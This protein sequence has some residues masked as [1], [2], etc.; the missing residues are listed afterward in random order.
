MK[1]RIIST[2]ILIFWICILASSPSFSQTKIQGKVVDTETNQP[3]S[4]VSICFQGTNNGTISNADG[5]FRFILKEEAPKELIFSCIGYETRKINI[6]NGVPAKI[7]MSKAIY[8]LRTLE[9]MGTKPDHDPTELFYLAVKNAKKN[10]Q[11]RSARSYLSLETLGS[12]DVPIEV[13]E[14]FYQSDYSIKHG[15]S[16]M[17]LKNG[18]FGMMDQDGQYFS[19]LQTTLMLTNYELFLQ[20][21]K[22]YYP[23]SPF[24]LSKSQGEEQYIFNLEKVIH[25]HEE[26]IAVINFIPRSGDQKL[27]G[28]QAFINMNDH[29]FRQIKMHIENSEQ[30]PFAPI[31]PIASL[32]GVNLDLTLNFRTDTEGKIMYDYILFNYDFDYVKPDQR[33]SMTTEALLVFYDYEQAFLMPMCNAMELTTDYEKIMAT[34]FHTYFWE[35]NYIYAQTKAMKDHTEYFIDNGVVINYEELCVDHKP[36]NNPIKVWSETDPISWDDFLIKDMKDLKIDTPRF[37]WNYQSLH[38]E[39]PVNLDFHIFLD[40]NIEGDSLYFCCR[41][42]FNRKASYYFDKKD[43]MA[44]AYINLQF[45]LVESVRRK[46]AES[47]CKRKIK[48]DNIG[49]IENVYQDYTKRLDKMMFSMLKDVQ[50]G[51]NQVKLAE[52]KQKVSADLNRTTAQLTP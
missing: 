9:I 31:S 40:C 1:T 49:E 6:D 46:M 50:R 17:N 36:V 20:A 28:G 24:S 45:D 26:L 42:V 13:L 12:D 16:E 43:S 14:A 7:Q 29:Q 3:I 23:Y 41:T 48:I 10:K 51:N 30:V 21:R 25:N 44:L 32:D 35:Q 37:T 52:W 5:C 22:S 15:L 2:G 34:P 18:R 11:L 38:P 8:S 33:E 47:L 27:F 39:S 19:S 4:Y